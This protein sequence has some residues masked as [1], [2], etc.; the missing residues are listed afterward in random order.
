MKSSSKVLSDGIM[1]NVRLTIYLITNKN[2]Y[3][4]N[5]HSKH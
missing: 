3:V 5:Y 1:N 2:K 4:N